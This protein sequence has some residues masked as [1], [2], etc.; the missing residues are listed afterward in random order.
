MYM[1]LCPVRRGARCCQPQWELIY[2]ACSQGAFAGHLACHLAAFQTPAASWGAF[3][4]RR[5][6]CPRLLL[7]RGAATLRARMNARTRL[8]AR[9][10]CHSQVRVGVIGIFMR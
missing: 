7:A 3:V 10:G 8:F 6:S 2:S 1:Q 4:E 5:D 9:A